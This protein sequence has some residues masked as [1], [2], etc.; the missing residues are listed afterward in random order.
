MVQKKEPGEIKDPA[1][2]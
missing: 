1:N 2:Y